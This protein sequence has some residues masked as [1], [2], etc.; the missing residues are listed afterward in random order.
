MPK[1]ASRI[2]LMVEEI[3]V[4][5]LQ[6]ISEE[7]A[8]AEGIESIDQHG[9]KVWKRYDGYSLVTSDPVVSFWSLWAS[10][11]GED[12]WLSNPWVWVVKYRILS[13]TGK[14]SIETIEKNYLEIT[15]KEVTN[16]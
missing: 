5:R 11:N 7:D 1:V 12:S 15:G 9:S 8:I 16:V 4:E 10:I 13:K 2:W 6:D 3:R 14:P